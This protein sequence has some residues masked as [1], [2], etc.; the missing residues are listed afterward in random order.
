M[1]LGWREPHEIARDLAGL[2]RKGIEVV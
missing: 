1:M 2:E